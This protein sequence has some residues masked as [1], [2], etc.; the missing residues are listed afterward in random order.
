MLKGCNGIWRGATVVKFSNL[1][2][3]TVL[4]VLT[5]MF[6]LSGCTSEKNK[7]IAELTKKVDEQLKISQE[8]SKQIE[9][10]KNV[11]EQDISSQNMLLQ[12]S[13]TKSVNEFINNNKE[14]FYGPIRNY[15]NHYNKKLNKCFV[16]LVG[17]YNGGDTFGYVLTDVNE[18]KDYGMYGQFNGKTRDCYVGDVSCVSESEWKVLIR[19]YMEE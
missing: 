1:I 11:K 7:Q 6:L 17:S 16:S 2:I 5:P 15:T 14:C 8:Q 18:N 10:L 9:E 12:E 4:S 3:F 19:P 13:C